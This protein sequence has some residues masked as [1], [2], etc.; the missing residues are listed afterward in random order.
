MNCQIITCIFLT[1]NIIDLRSN[2]LY[3]D[4]QNDALVLTI[5][6]HLSTVRVSLVFFLSILAY[7]YE[8]IHYLTSLESLLAITK[9]LIRTVLYT[10]AIMNFIYRVHITKLHGNISFSRI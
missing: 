2:G 7:F 5:K 8:H 1:M 9:C 3:I 4:R 10:Q 6:Y